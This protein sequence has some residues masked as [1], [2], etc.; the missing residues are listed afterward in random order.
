MGASDEEQHRPQEPHR[1]CHYWVFSPVCGGAFL[2][3]G[4]LVLVPFI[5]GG[6]TPLPWFGMMP[7][8]FPA[9][10]LK[11]FPTMFVLIDILAQRFQLPL[12]LVYPSPVDILSVPLSPLEP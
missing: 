8:E 5:I 10:N 3:E 4:L 2:T 1:L 9:G 7:I 12:P 11:H 6:L